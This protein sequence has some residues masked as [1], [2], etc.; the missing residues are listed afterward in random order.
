MSIMPFY[1]VAPQ[2]ICIGEYRNTKT[3]PSPIALQL[4]TIWKSLFTL[5]LSVISAMLLREKNKLKAVPEKR[6]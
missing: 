6:R 2:T 1:T 5:R 3:K 4:D